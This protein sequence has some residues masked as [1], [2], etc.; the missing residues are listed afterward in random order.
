MNLVSLAMQFLGPVILNRIAS[1][2]GVNQGLV[3][4]AV[5]AAI[6]AILAGL[7]GRTANPAGANALGNVLSKVDPGILGN[8]GNLIGGAGQQ[9]LVEGGSNALGALLGGPAQSALTSA[10]GKFAGLDGSQSSS[11]VGM[12]A[13]VVLGTLAKQQR[14]SGLDAGGI[15]NLLASQKSN[16]AA[17]MPA[18]LSSM[19]QG[20][21]LL[22]SIAGNLKAAAPAAPAMPAAPRGGLPGWLFPL[23]LGLAGLYLVSSYGCDRSHKEAVTEKPAA[24]QPATKA[25]EA[26]PAQKS[27]T[28]A[29]APSGSNDLAGLA[30]KALNALTTSLATIKDEASAKAAVPAL[31][32]TSKQIDGLK[33]AAMLLQGEARKPVSSLIAAALPGITGVVEKAVGIPGV[34]AIITPVVEPMV[35]NLTELSK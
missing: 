13:P 35:K 18:E 31:Q 9:Q 6:P 21:G 16:I 23:V 4:K 15:A 12:M 22:D 28:P 26:A 17:A 8:L 11:L 34:A 24:T 30:G 19:L 10:I 14:E 33:A 5:T 7:A 1:S 20:T 2:L 3:G 25:P 27:E 29:P 32:D